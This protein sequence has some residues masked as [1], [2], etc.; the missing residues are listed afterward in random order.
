[1]LVVKSNTLK[2]AV[3]KSVLNEY[4]VKSNEM[5]KD[6][7]TYGTEII[8]PVYDPFLLE[9]LREMS[10]THDSCITV[11][12]EDAIFSGKKFVSE[13]NDIPEQIR[14]LLDDFDFDEELESFLEDYETF[15]YA[16]LEFL[17]DNEMNFVGINHIS[18]LYLRM[19]RDKERVVQK[20][21]AKEVYFK[22]YN[23][24]DNRFLNKENGL[25]DYDINSETLANDIVWF[26]KK[27]SESKVYGKPRYLSELPAIITDE[28]I[29]DYQKGYFK[30]HGVPNYIIT[31]TGNLESEDENYT[32]DDF[33]ADLE[34]EFKSISNEPGTALCVVIPSDEN[35][36]NVNVHK[37]G[38][39]RKEGSF[40]DLSKKVTD[41]IYRV[42]RVPKERVG[43]SDASGIASNRTE[44]LLKNYSKSTVAIIQRRIANLVNKAILKSEFESDVKIEFLPA[45]F[46]GEDTQL[47]RLIKLLQNGALTLGEFINRLPEKYLLEMEESDIYFDKR[48]MNNQSLDVVLFGNVPMDAEGKLESLINDLD[49]DMNY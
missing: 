1:M 7:L 14:N 23:P 29:I 28:A 5:S 17:R 41:R 39:E 32:A 18:S 40:L 45:N 11:K 42:H 8:E 48:F 44:A 30:S 22:L 4:D 15:G 2:D 13:S 43:D 6:E 27:S 21:G 16:G 38:E 3:I 46:E 33:E 49:E 26:N 31:I 9:K 19:C 35:N 20:I 10:G 36:V 24:K 37:I 34:N 25:W 47:D 12:A